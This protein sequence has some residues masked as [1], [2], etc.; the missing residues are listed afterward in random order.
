MIMDGPLAEL[1]Y[2]A[3]ITRNIQG[4]LPSNASTQTFTQS[5]PMAAYIFQEAPFNSLNYIH[6]CKSTVHDLLACTKL[7]IIEICHFVCYRKSL[8]HATPN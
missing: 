6:K 7:E 4:K 2:P 5:V 8:H 1:C 3:R